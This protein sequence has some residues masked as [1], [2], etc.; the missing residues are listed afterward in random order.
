L[1]LLIALISTHANAQWFP[2]V[3]RKGDV[4]G[5][6]G[7]N[8]DIYSKSDIHFKGDDYDFTLFDV[9]AKDRQTKFKAETY[10]GLNT[11]TIPQTNMRF[12]YFIHEN[13]AITAGVDHMKYVMAQY[14]K[15]RFEGTI[16]DKEYAKL[17]TD[18]NIII[19]PDFLK[20]EHTDGL[21]YINTE[22][23]Y[24]QGIYHGKN[25]HLNAIGGVG[26]GAMLP[27]TNV[28]LMGYPRNDAFHL[29][30]AG[31]DAKLALEALFWKYFFIRFEGKVGYINMPSIVT[32]K[33]DIGDR[34]SQQFWFGSANG[35]FGFNIPT[36][37]KPELTK[38]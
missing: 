13:L 16:D 8:R 5:C 4:F 9:I 27:K 12:G 21:N 3:E 25:I 28:T 19:V 7:W 35:M 6:W 38:E 22:L 18:G 10:F 11:I 29:A 34:A 20:F 1:F 15:V 32:R 17:V 23:E 37:K 26:V 24:H 33:A 2:K 31:T 36:R 30:G 14:Q